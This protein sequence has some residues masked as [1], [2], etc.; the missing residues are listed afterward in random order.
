M[1]TSLPLPDGTSCTLNYHV[2]GEEHMRTIFC[3]HG[4][5]RNGMD[6]EKLALAAADK[7]FRVI[8]PDMPGR[9]QSPALSNPALYNNV[10]NAQLCLALL[11]TLGLTSVDWIGTSMGGMIAMLVAN[12]SPATIHRLVL[13][14]IGCFVPASSLKRIVEYGGEATYPTFPQA[15]EALKTRTQGFAVPAADWPRFAQHSIMQT[16]RGFRLAYDPAIISALANIDIKDVD[17][18]PLWEAL[19]PIPLLLVRGEQSD[20]LTEETA[21]K[22]QATHPQLTRYNVAAAGH[23]P[24]LMS[25]TEI[26][27]VLG[28]MG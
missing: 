9:G 12:Q 26:D 3:V 8:A 28:F 13:N 20:L 2:W 22:M 10:V 14:D 7:G 4:L 19:K 1:L 6:F 16:D 5:T 15:E 21:Q 17:L 11:G 27:V 23:A 25:E 24:A 18:W